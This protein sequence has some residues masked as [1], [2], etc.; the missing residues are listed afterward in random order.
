MTLT[1]WNRQRQPIRVAVAGARVGALLDVRLAMPVGGARAAVRRV[2][3]PSDGRKQ[4]LLGCDAVL[5]RRPRLHLDGAPRL[6][7]RERA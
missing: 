4:H 3:R 2:A 1:G 7:V 5:R 6:G